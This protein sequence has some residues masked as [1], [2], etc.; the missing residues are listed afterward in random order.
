MIDILVV[1]IPEFYFLIT[2][3]VWSKNYMVTLLLIGHTC[4]FPTMEN[5]IKFI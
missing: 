3:R 2:S 4:G 1:D 5:P